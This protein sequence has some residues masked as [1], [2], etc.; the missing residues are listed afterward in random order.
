MI[1]CYNEIVIGT[2]LLSQK[3]RKRGWMTINT[4][5]LFYV[6]DNNVDKWIKQTAFVAQNCQQHSLIYGASWANIYF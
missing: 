5:A 3:G 1:F 6:Y 4:Y 2:Q